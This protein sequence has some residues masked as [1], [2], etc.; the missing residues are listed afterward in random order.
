MIS[1]CNYTFILL[2]LPYLFLSIIN[3]VKSGKLITVI[4]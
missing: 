4:K 1:F 3:D 2:L